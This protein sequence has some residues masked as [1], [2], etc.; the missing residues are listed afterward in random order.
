MMW[1]TVFKMGREIIK[2]NMKKE[3]KYNII[4]MMI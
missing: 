3:V 2:E 4:Y 1:F